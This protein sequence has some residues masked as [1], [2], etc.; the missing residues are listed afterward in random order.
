MTHR[1]YDSRAH[2]ELER[3]LNSMFPN[4]GIERLTKKESA[5][6]WAHA[7]TGSRPKRV[8][9]DSV[10]SMLVFF[11]VSAPEPVPVVAFG[12]KAFQEPDGN[13]L[14]FAR[15]YAR[16]FNE[17][18][19]TA[20]EVR[21]Q[22]ELWSS[23]QQARFSRA[24]G[25][26]SPFTTENFMRWLRTVENA[27]SLRYEGRPFAAS[28]LMTKQIE[29]VETAEGASFVQFSQPLRFEWA[30]LQEK[31]IRSLIGRSGLAL[32]GLSVAGRI[33][34]LITITGLNGKGQLIAPHSDLDPIVSNVVP[35]TM[36]FIAARTGD[37]YVLLPQGAVFLKHQ[38]RWQYLN[39]KWLQRAMASLARETTVNAVMRIILDLSFDRTGGLIVVLDNENDICKT[40]P[41]HNS[42]DRSN[43]ELRSFVRGLEI[44]NKSH[45]TIIRAAVSIDGATILSRS[46][47]VLDAAC[48]VGDP[49]PEDR[50]HVGQSGLR[51]FAGARSTAA[52]NS[53]IYGIS[54]KVSED[55]PITVFQNGNIVLEM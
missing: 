42:P 18:L 24:I 31:W 36:L 9:W 6:V 21:S 3:A 5:R 27:S 7:H 34:G 40:I 47:Q 51:R 48:M 4:R 53:S 20:R 43:R 44:A 26:F 28:I 55:G 35:G 1:V 19:V 2:E 54:V 39:Y 13:D 29:W 52:W 32:V 49:S 14:K 22:D 46:G 8:V 16:V 50:H 25:R 12:L 30:I 37:T 45:R 17:D 10:N 33:V 15:T 23:L 11:L 38:G 41:D